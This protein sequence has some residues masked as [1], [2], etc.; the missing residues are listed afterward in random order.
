MIQIPQPIIL[1]YK[2]VNKGKHSSVRHYEL[3][4]VKNGSSRLSSQ[5]NISKDR[6]F[7]KSNPEYW[8]KV[9]EG[10]KWSKPVSGLF[11]TNLDE[12]F[13]GDLNNKQHLIILKFSNNGEDVTL[14]LFQSYFSLDLSNVLRLIN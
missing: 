11:K 10:N 4:E 6:G 7:A 14:Y 5:L 8:L 1:F 12:V 13:R 2:E 3:I 9:R